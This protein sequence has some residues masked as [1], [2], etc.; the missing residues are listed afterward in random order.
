ML[1]VKL[2]ELRIAHG[3][4]L[5]GLAKKA[6]LSKS[7]LWGLEKN[8]HNKVSAKNLAAISSVLGVTSEYFLNDTLQEPND[9]ILDSAFYEQYL[10]LDSESKRRMR[11]ILAT[12]VKD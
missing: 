1:S 5:E 2:K 10:K 12:F 11:L 6:G 4:T 8:L 9:R 3:L 7:F